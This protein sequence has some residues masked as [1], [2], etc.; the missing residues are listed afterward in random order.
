MQCT[1]HRQ[2]AKALLDSL[3]KRRL[4]ETSKLMA[5]K[6]ALELI[7]LPQDAEECLWQILLSYDRRAF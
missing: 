3:I 5:L 6:D 1:G 4:E 7:D 2:T